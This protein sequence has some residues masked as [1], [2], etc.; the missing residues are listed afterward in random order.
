V[1]GIRRN[2]KLPKEFVGCLQW[3]VLHALLEAEFQRHVK[4]RF[5]TGIV[6]W[7]LKGHYPCGWEGSYP[8]GR[9]IVF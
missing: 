8:E 5:N 6:A 2:H 9:L 1:R 7:Y 3:C 4:T